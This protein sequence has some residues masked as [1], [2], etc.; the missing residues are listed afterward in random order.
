MASLEE[1]AAVLALVS[2]TTDEWYRT[3]AL[4]DEAGSALRIVNRDWNGFEPFDVAAAERLGSQVTKAD[5]ERQ[6]GVIQDL[7]ERGIRIVTI[8]D[9]AY[10]LNLRAIYN[11]PPMLFV[12][13][14]LQPDDERAIAVVGTRSASPEGLKLAGGLAT[15]LALSRVTVL[16]GLA[17]GIDTAA[18]R[19]AL[20][21][22]GRTIAVMGTGLNTVYPPENQELAEQIAE[23]GA[24][25]SQFW[26]DA[27]P[28]KFSFPMRNVV[29]SG[30]SFGTVVI[31]ASE[32]SGARM[33]AR[34]ALEHGKR[35]F[36][37]EQLVMKQEWARKYAEHPSTTVVHSVD[38]ILGALM[39][40]TR[41]ARQLSFG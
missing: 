28:T 7:Y 11:R 39:S 4:I 23:R 37:V 41:P 22:G 34:F 27:P 35:V 9:D 1:Q 3:A 17:R 10:P 18:H 21:A 12:R 6:R 40:V 15:Q 2:A 29:M 13:G 31:E 19:A 30:M 26:P 16:S 38:D 36:L 24:L 14:S 25:V 32:T 5:V 8:L 33:Q 20:S